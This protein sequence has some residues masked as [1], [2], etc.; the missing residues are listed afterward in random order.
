VLSLVRAKQAL[1]AVVAEQAPKPNITKPVLLNPTLKAA[2]AKPD[3]NPAKS[4][5]RL[6]LVMNVFRPTSQSKVSAQNALE[7]VFYFKRLAES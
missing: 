1:D 4:I 2:T 7:S 3:S 6:N 5:Q